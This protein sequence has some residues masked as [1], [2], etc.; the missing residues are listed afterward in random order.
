MSARLILLVSQD[1]SIATMLHVC[2]RYLAGWQVVSMELE[3]GLVERVVEECP[4]AILLDVFLPKVYPLGF[5]QRLFIQ[6]LKRER[7]TQSVPIVL[8]SDKATWFTDEQL[9][10]LG[11][12]GAIAKPFD[13]TTLPTQI[14]HL[15]G[16]ERST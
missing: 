9:R 7:L 1:A 14:A 15:L 4:D 11:I 2:L 13:P 3:Q 12:E 16:W 8:I 6:K 10:S 5:I